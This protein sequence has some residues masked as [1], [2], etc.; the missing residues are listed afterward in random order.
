MRKKKKPVKR[1]KSVK[2][3]VKVTRKKKGKVIKYDFERPIQLTFRFR[4]K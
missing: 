2:R 4:R 1:K 3:K